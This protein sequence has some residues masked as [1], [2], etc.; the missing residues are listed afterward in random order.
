MTDAQTR[1]QDQPDADG[2]ATLTLHGSKALNII[3]TPAILAA[4]EAPEGVCGHPG[5]RVLVLRGPTLL[6]QQ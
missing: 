5:L 2:I 4:T 1:S 3:G 6:R